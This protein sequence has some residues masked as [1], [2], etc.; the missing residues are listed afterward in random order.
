[1]NHLHLLIPDLFLAREEAAHVCAG[2]HL[3]ALEVLLARAEPAILPATT[4]EDFLCARFGATAAAPVR[5]AADGLD[6][7]DGFWVC[8]DPVHLQ[9]RGSQ[10]LLLPQVACTEEEAAALCATLNGHFAADGLSFFAPQPQ[11][12]YIRC[13]RPSDVAFPPLSAAAWRDAKLLRASGADALHWQCVG[14]ETQMLLHGHAVNLAREARALPAINSVWLWGGGSAAALHADFDAVGG[15]D[16][17]SL[18]FARATGL[19][20]PRPLSAMLEETDANALWVCATPAEA[21]RR[22]DLYAWREAVGALER[23]VALPLL[24]ALRSG[25][26]H[27]LALEVLLERETWHFALTRADVFKLWRARRPLAQYAV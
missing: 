9:M 7:G 3:P 21:W 2:L 14:N 26:L 17:L 27:S 23:D 5:A 1:M 12:W 8:A 22:G 16:E 24:G 19:A 18:A 13:A 20:C 15:D 25:R 11:R 10:V 4:R 6:T